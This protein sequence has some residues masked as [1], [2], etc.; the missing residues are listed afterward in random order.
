MAFRRIDLL[1]CFNS[2]K[3]ITIEIL[4]IIISSIGTI[5]CILGIIFIPWKVTNRAME[6][7]FIIGLIFIVLSI[8]IA[9]IIFYFRLKH[10]LTRRIIR[11]LI[12]ALII[13]LFI[14]F[15]SLI[16]FIILAFG[17]ISDLNNKETTIIMEIIEETGEVKNRTTIEND[18]TTKPKKIFSILIISFLILIWIFLLFLWVSEYIRLFFNTELSYKDYIEQ[19]KKKQLKHP[20][21]YGLNVVGHDKYGFPIFGK[22]I[23][24]SI[25]IKGV[26]SSFEEKT[27]EKFSSKYIDEKGKIN[28]RCYSKY[29]QKPSKNESEKKEKYIEKYLSGESVDDFQNYDNFFNKTIFNLE[30]NNNSI[31]PGYDIM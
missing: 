5:L 19:E 16:I 3:A 22:Q 30:E 7:L 31:N 15:I 2:F 14:C 21:K 27:T 10:K 6:I 18:L 4:L 12:F 29:S 28:F 26:K 23:G 11:V 8:I 25:I 24:N 20:I 13:I 1:L 17:T 9:L